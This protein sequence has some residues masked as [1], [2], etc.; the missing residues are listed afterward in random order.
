MSWSIRI[1]GVTP[2]EVIEQLTN[3]PAPS[4]L[5]PAGVAAFNGCRTALI[6]QVNAV[7]DTGVPVYVDGIVA[8]LSGHIS[9][10]GLGGFSAWLD[11][12]G[13]ARPVVEP[14]AVPEGTPPSDE[15]VPLPEDLVVSPLTK[16]EEALVES[17][18]AAPEPGEEEFL[19]NEEAQQPPVIS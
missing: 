18:I 9:A 17:T 16:D 3:R 10:N 1:D 11:F 14:T 19:Q 8:T 12:S 15:G 5:T 4:D 13:V 6:A 7:K 2:Q